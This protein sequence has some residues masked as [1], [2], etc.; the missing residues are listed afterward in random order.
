VATIE[1]ELIT[2]RKKGNSHTAEEESRYQSLLRD[3]MEAKKFY[4]V[5]LEK[6]KQADISTTLENQQHGERV[7]ILELASLPHS[8]SFPN[9]ILFAIAGFAVGALLA[10]TLALGFSNRE[11]LSSSS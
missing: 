1:K 7:Q 5:L 6:S 11:S 3:Y 4:E 8:P 2:Y 10:I 9:R